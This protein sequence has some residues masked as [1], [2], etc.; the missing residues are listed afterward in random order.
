MELFTEHFTRTFA[1]VFAGDGRDHALLRGG[2]CARLNVFAHLFAGLENS[3][4]NKIADDL[5]DIAAHIADLR[6]L[7]RLDLYEGCAG[8]LGEA[9]GNLGFA[10]TCRADHQDILRINLI[11]Q[12]IRQLLA[13]PARAQR[14][15]DCALGIGLTN[16][17]AVQLGDDFTGG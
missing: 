8:Q 14:H 9:A 13:P 12:I 4:I 6:K 17:E 5:L 3:G 1:R 2:M 7:R 10:D 16:D 15:G 11:A